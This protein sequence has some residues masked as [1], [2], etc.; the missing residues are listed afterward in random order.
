MCESWASFSRDCVY[1]SLCLHIY[2][3]MHIGHGI[4][5]GG[6]VRAGLIGPFKIWFRLTEVFFS[7]S[8]KWGFQDSGQLGG[9][10]MDDKKKKI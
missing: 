5:K 2:A 4:W 6:V 7:G 8:G 9:Q 3:V 1:G 10:M